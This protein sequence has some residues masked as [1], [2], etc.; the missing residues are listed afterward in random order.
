MVKHAYNGLRQ[1]SISSEDWCFLGRKRELC[2]LIPETR[3]IRGVEVLL[4]R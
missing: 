1:V 4:G 2:G 3:R